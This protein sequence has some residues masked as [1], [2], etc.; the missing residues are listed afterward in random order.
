MGGLVRSRDRQK[1]ETEIIMI[2]TAR[3]AEEQLRL[4]ARSTISARPASAFRNFL[5][6][7]LQVSAL[8]GH[9]QLQY[10][11]PGITPFERKKPMAKI[12]LDRIGALI[13]GLLDGSLQ[14]TVSSTGKRISSPRGRPKPVSRPAKKVLKKKGKPG[15]PSLSP[16]EKRKRAAQAK[17]SRIRKQKQAL[18]S[19]RD[20]LLFMV[21]QRDGLKLSDIARQFGVSRLI[22]KPFLAKLLAKGDLTELHGR[23]YLKRRVR[24]P[25]KPP[26]EIPVPISETVVLEYLG[27]NGPTTLSAMAKAMNEP[28]YHRLIRVTNALKKSGKVTSEGKTYHLTS[29]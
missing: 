11:P 17:T 4:T 3:L 19:P 1:A 20:L 7:S 21:D 9:R 12:V 5:L 10:L 13:R 25:G 29:T 16:T 24:V 26:R 22:I 8:R 18:P 2:V 14:I 6:S 15:R 27:K 28:S 23:L